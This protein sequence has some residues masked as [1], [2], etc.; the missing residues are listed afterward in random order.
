LILVILVD[1]ESEL[2]R[3]HPMIANAKTATINLEMTGKRFGITLFLLRNWKYFRT[4]QRFA[5]QSASTKKE[6]RR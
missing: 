2:L 4:L 3:S 6:R 1:E 5:Q